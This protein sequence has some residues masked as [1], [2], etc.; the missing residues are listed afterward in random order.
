M[1]EIAIIGAGQSGLQLAIALKRK[2]FNV[3]VFSN[4]LPDQI[5]TGR[6][7]SSQGMFH[8]ALT[9]ERALGIDL[10]ELKSPQNTAMTF[11]LADPITH[12]PIIQWQSLLPPYQ[13]IDQRIKIPEWMEIF[14]NDGGNLIIKDVD[15]SD[16]YQI[17]QS[18][19]L[20]I[21]SAGKSEICQLFKINE[22]ESPFKTPQRMLS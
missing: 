5:R 19:D 22:Q 1:R 9:I 7:L 2:N 12:S 14:Q 3:S 17:S 18:H 21:V 4:R 15:I 10:W 6:I 20:T 16:L 8:T 11:I 13:S